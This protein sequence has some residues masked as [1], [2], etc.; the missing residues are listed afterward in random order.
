MVRRWLLPSLALCAAAPAFA[1]DDGPIP[2]YYA[3]GS[4][5]LSAGDVRLVEAVAGLAGKGSFIR[6]SGHSDRTGSAEANRRL[7]ERRVAGVRAA[8]IAAGMPA[9]RIMAQSFGERGA[10][11]ALEDGRADGAH[12]YVLVEVLS[13]AEAGKGRAGRATRWTCG[14]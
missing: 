7:T 8:L 1:C 13:A 12:R 11:T 3:S 14:G 2:I 5:R 6:L 10:S 9:E 4:A